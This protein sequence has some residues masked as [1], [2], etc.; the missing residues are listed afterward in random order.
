MQ[1]YYEVSNS[2]INI[3]N[4]HSNNLKSKFNVKLGDAS[5]KIPHIY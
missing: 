2:N 4:N 1:T 3:T 5:K